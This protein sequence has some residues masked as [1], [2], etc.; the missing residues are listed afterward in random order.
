MGQQAA[1]LLSA[2]WALGP[3]VVAER[4]CS[5]ACE[6]CEQTRA[7]G[8]AEKK[9]QEGGGELK[10]PQPSAGETNTACCCIAVALQAQPRACTEEE[11]RELWDSLRKKCQQK[12]RAQA[13]PPKAWKEEREQWEAQVLQAVKHSTS[14]RRL[15]CCPGTSPVLS[16]LSLCRAAAFVALRSG[17]ERA[18]KSCPWRMRRAQRTS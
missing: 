14:S 8:E 17:G 7:D 13:A 9:G 3:G 12:A 15:P 10:S 16:P 11:G 18:E 1:G 4:L 5:G 6:D 2:P